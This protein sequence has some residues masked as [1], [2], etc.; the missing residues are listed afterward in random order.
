MTSYCE[1]EGPGIITVV[2]LIRKVWSEICILNS[3]SP[4]HITPTPFL[5]FL[6]PSRSCYAGRGYIRAICV[7]RI[8]ENPSRIDHVAVSGNCV[9]PSGFQDSI[10]RS[11][12]K[13]KATKN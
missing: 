8:S 13:K 12:E 10:L 3:M 5:L 2:K 9:K 4:V 6:A 7:Q 11:S 1:S